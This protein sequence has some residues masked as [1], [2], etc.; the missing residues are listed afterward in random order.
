MS[1]VTQPASSRAGILIQVHVLWSQCV[2]SM[3]VRDSSP[4][5]QDPAKASSRENMDG[6]KRFCLCL[7]LKKKTWEILKE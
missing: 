2:V 3:D 7:K 4:G 6:I 5:T 1:K